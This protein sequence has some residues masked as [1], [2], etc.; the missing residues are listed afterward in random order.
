M[1][2]PSFFPDISA[3]TESQQASPVTRE[4]DRVADR[5]GFV[6]RAQAPTVLQKRCKTVE[7]ATHSF[8]C[9]ISVRSAN[10]FIS[11]CEREGLSYRQGFDHLMTLLTNYPDEPV[12]R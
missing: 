8:T 1:T 10:G 11:W 12:K 6:D 5:L 3:P 2:R 4:I 9:R 7:E